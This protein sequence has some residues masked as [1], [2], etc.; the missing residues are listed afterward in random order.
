V[1]GKIVLQLSGVGLHVRQVV[2]HEEHLLRGVS[3]VDSR[4]V[5]GAVVIAVKPVLNREVTIANMA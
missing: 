1:W 2:P 5:P 4:S 3:A